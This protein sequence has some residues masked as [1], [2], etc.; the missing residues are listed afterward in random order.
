MKRQSLFSIP[1]HAPFLPTLVDKI[2]DGTLPRPALNTPFGLA[3]LTIFVP[4]R[5]ARAALVEA[6]AARIEGPLLLP[7]IRTLAENP[8]EEAP[9]LPPFSTAPLPDILPAAQRRLLLAQFVQRWIESADKIPFSAP[10]ETGFASPPS[11]NEIW[12]LADALGGLIDDMIIAGVPFSR[13]KEIGPE[14][15]AENWQNSLSFLQIVLGAWP[16]ILAERGAVDPATARNRA[17]AQRAEAALAFY[18]DKP[19]IVAGSTGTLPATARLIKAIAGLPNGAVVLPGL[20]TSLSEADHMAL[21]DDAKA[22]HGHP[23]HGLMRLLRV[24]GSGPGAVT[25]L[26]PSTGAGAVRGHILAQ[27]LA[28]PEQTGNWASARAGFSE[29]ALEGPLWGLS[30]LVGRSEEEEARAV[31]VAAR[32]TLGEGKTVGIVT[33]DRNLAR[34]V[35]AELARF[36]IAIDDGAGT[37]LFQSP[38]GRLV[39]QAVALVLSDWAPV[40]LI[41]LLR[42]R[43]VTL[44]GERGH[45]AAMADRLELAFLRGQRPAPGRAGLD[46]LIAANLA[47]DLPRQPVQLDKAMADE[48]KETL[49]RLD[50]ALAPLLAVQSSENVLAAALAAAVQQAVSDLVGARGDTHRPQGWSELMRWAEALGAEGAQGPG[51]SGPEAMRALSGLMAGVSVRPTVASRSDVALLGLL[52]ARGLSFDLTVLCGLNEG[53][54]PPAADPGPFLSRDMAIALGLAPPERRHGQMAHDFVMGLG[55]GQTVLALADRVGTAPAAPSRLIQRLEAFVGRKWSAALRA[56]G[57]V[58]RTQ[59]GRLDFVAAPQAAPRPVPKPPAALRPR[60]LSITEI[61]TLIRSPYDLYAKYVLRLLPLPPL[62]HDPDFAE[63]GTLLHDILARFIGAGHDPAAPEAF[64]ILMAVADQVLEELATAPERRAVWRQR[65]A[66]QGRAFLDFEVGR[67]A[68]VRERHV[69]AGGK[70]TFEIAGT[71]FTLRG[72]ADRIDELSSGKLAIFDFKTG[73]VP[74]K[75][76]MTALLAPQLP[77]EALMAREGAFAGVPAAASTELGYL[78]LSSGPDALQPRPFVTPPGRG[79]MDAADDL[80]VRLQGHVAALLLR[81]DHPLPPRLLPKT[82]QGYRGDYEHL[83]RTE[84]WTLVGG[85]EE[86]AE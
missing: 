83:A 24:L 10:G 42:N 11:P 38:A 47:G 13:L 66:A 27:A 18:G 77:L 75:S 26:G 51:F 30:I 12:A 80:F 85:D 14:A 36:G 53:V 54:W 5:R 82:R 7:D 50:E 60:S 34:R 67:A 22:P 72:R 74:D 65:F 76:E 84:E 3:D 37:P 61:E 1:P 70:W 32:A 78:K 68:M 48:L 79:L 25:D 29:T 43:H 28:L 71:P 20:D 41:A 17:I 62:G 6:F 64:D 4:T 2:V 8:E 52:E 19:V 46:A 45:I 58:W 49:G 40:D 15:L 31:A 73:A 16:D 56:R 81:D 23:Q 55:G 57:A 69:E 9:F 59:A 63:R 44:S 86:G 35:A 33:P 21:L 39:R